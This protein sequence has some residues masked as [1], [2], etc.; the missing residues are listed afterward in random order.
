MRDVAVVGFAQSTSAR[1]VDRNE[2]E[3]LMPVVSAAME[4]SGLTHEDIGFTCSGSNDYLIGGPFSFVS[5]LDA[6]GA[7]PPIAESHVEMDGAFALYEAWVKLQL[8]HIDAALVYSFGKSSMTDLGELTPLALDPY[9]LLPLWPDHVSLAA[10]QARAYLDA[11]GRT[12]AD[13][14]EVAARSRTRAVANPH[15]I[16]QGETTAAAMLQEDLVVSPLRTGDVPP[17]TDGAAAVV[18]AAGDALDRTRTRAAHITGLDHRI[19]AHQPGARDLARSTSTEL[20]AERAGVGEGAIDVAELHAAF[21]HEELILRAAL[22][23]DDGVDVNP[24]GGALVSNPWMTTGLIRIGEA[25]NR[26]FDGGATRV[27]AHAT[28]GPCLQQNLVCVME[29]RS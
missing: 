9:S 3:M 29:A 7:W 19:E 27:V 26:I 22:G 28:A 16:V 6:V 2:V 25:A 20:A 24:S 17:V 21:S 11:A 4:H 8:G 13:L 10:L 18:L 1:D 5:A 14:A 23:L 15:A 12:E